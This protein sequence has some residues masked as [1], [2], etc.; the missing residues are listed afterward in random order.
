MF[1]Q[2]TCGDRDFR[3]LA[4]QIRQAI[5]PE[6]TDFIVDTVL[7]RSIEATKREA[8]LLS[9]SLAVIRGIRSGNSVTS[10]LPPP[11][12]GFQPSNARSRVRRAYRRHKRHKRHSM[13]LSTHP[14]T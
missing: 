5:G 6:L 10:L 13:K 11:E 12:A 3:G 7:D 9:L 2:N 1:T 8:P 4:D 14:N